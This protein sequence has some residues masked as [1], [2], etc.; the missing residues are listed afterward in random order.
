MR[1]FGATTFLVKVFFNII[2]SPSKYVIVVRRK[3]PL[4]D[5]NIIFESTAIIMTTIIMRLL[6]HY[7]IILR[8][9]VAVRGRYFDY[10]GDRIKVSNTENRSRVSSSSRSFL[11]KTRFSKVYI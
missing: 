8:A 10:D 5:D 2:D 6:K 11:P 7:N 9:T 3:R 1:V 4:F